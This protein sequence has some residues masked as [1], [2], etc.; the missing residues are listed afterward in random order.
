MRERE[1]ESEEKWKK[2]M[3]VEGVRECVSTKRTSIVEIICSV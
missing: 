3:R 2:E 1:R